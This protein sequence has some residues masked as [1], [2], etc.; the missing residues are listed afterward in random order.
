MTEEW[1]V[2]ENTLN[3]EISNCGEVRNKTTKKILK[4]QLLNGY[5]GIT[6]KTN[7]KK[8]L[9]KIHRLVATHFLIC[10]DE[11]Y[12]VNHKDGNKT[13]NNVKNL[14]WISQT[15]NVKHAF[16][17]G[18]NEGKKN[19]VYQYTLE[20]VFIREYN[21]PIDVENETGIPRTR[22]L[23]V[24]E[25]KTRKTGGYIWKY[26]DEYT[27]TQPIPEG[28]TM[29]EYPNYIITN[30]GKIYNSQRKRFLCLKKH[31]NGYIGIALT[32]YDNKRKNFYAHRLVAL[33]FI[34][35]PNNYPEVNHIDF[36]KTNNKIENLEWISRSG[37]SKHNLSRNIQIPL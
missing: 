29:T 34:D 35:N 16:R 19:K 13:N 20:N 24:C 17:L 5:L 4:S 8:T 10:P 12:V 21:S 1:R 37:N 15:E 2:I 23:D 18:L 9:S 7:N 25:G 6:L 26:S 36:D 32:R 3:Y 11:T 22:I 14:E 30:D 28:K 31:V 27:A 33:L